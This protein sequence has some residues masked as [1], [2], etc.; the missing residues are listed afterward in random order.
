MTTVKDSTTVR[1]EEGVADAIQK[2]YLDD[3]GLDLST[4]NDAISYLI[5]RDAILSEL[6]NDP[7]ITARIEAIERDWRIQEIE[8]E[9]AKL[10]NEARE[11]KRLAPASRAEVRA[12]A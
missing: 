4:V 1:I 8:E 2:N 3:K 9:L 11:A 10:K 12:T 6:Q 7:A 5:D